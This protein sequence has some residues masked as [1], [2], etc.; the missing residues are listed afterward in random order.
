MWSG[1]AGD[2]CRCLRGALVLL[3]F[4]FRARA[5][6]LWWRSAR[7]LARAAALPGAADV[8]PRWS[9]VTHLADA[10]IGN[11]QASELDG[12]RGKCVF[13]AQCRGRTARGMARLTRS[14]PTPY[15]G[16]PT[17]T[18]PTCRSSKEA[19][20]SRLGPGF[21]DPHPR[22]LPKGTRAKYM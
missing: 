16:S 19:A 21:S 17:W 5:R 7:G 20:Q 3:F 22:R 11:A 4:P 13:P 1:P 10:A 18:A 14:P 6:A 15:W 12:S 2:D 8:A 9:S